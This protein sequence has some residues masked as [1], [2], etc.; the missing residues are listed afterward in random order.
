MNLPP[1]YERGDG[2]VREPFPIDDEVEPVEKELPEEIE[3][4]AD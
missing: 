3:P 2:I 1:E 4:E